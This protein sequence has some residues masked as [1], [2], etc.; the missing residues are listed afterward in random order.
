MYKRHQIFFRARRILQEIHKK[1]S[2][3]ARPLTNLLAK[4]VPFHFNDGCIKAWEKLK[5]ELFSAP[6]IL[7]SN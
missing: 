1:F 2:M 4:D 5:K 3:I 6:I 7:A